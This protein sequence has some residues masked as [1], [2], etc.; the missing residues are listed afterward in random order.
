M[1]KEEGYPSTMEKYKATLKENEIRCTHQRME[2]LRYLDENRTHPTVAQIHSGL[3]GENPSLSK[4]TVYNALQEFEEHGIV[5]SITQPD[6]KVRYD[7]DTSMHF[8]F[9]CDNC[10]KII[11]FSMDY[12]DLEQVKNRGHRV[13]KVQGYIRGVCKECLEEAGKSEEG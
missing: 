8:H 12:P 13:D 2:V 6:S 10:G 1:K 3:K 4:A 9:I 5:K 11:D 7:Y